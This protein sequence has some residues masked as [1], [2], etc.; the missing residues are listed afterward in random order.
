MKAKE[1]EIQDIAG[2]RPL[3]P[4]GPPPANTTPSQL[5]APS[6]TPSPDQELS[7]GLPLDSTDAGSAANLDYQEIAKKRTANLQ[8]TLKMTQ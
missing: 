6:W 8:R 5:P 2:F 7:S 3:P 1:L 4:D